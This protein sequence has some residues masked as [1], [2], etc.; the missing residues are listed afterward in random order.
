MADKLTVEAWSLRKIAMD[1]ADERIPDLIAN[2]GDA[3]GRGID[4]RITSSG[5]PLSLEGMTAFLAWRHDNGNQDMTRFDVVDAPGG[6]VRVKYPPAMMH[7]G[8]VIARVAVYVDTDTPITGSR[9]FRIL[10]EESPII[11]GEA[12][13]D[14]SF[15]LFKQAVAE[16][17]EF[18]ATAIAQEEARKK[19]EAERVLAEQ[20]RKNA[21]QTRINTD[22]ARIAAEAARATAETGRVQAEKNRVLAESG[23]DQ[24]FTRAETSVAQAVG[25]ANDAAS[26]ANSAAAAAAAVLD[27]APTGLKNANIIVI[28]DSFVMGNGASHGWAY[29]LK[30]ALP[31][32]AKVTAYGG[33]G[34]GFTKGASSNNTGGVQGKNFGQML[35]YAYQTQK[36]EA[37][38]VTHVIVQGSG[39]DAGKTSQVINSIKSFASSARAK[40]P[41]AEICAVPLQY[42]MNGSARLSTDYINEYVA[43]IRGGAQAGMAV[44]HDAFVWMMTD[45][46][47]TSTDNMHPNEA[48]YMKAGYSCASWLAGG[49]GGAVEYVNKHTMGPSVSSNS[50]Y[51]YIKDGVAY[52]GGNVKLSKQASNSDVLLTLPRAMWPSFTHYNLCII[53]GSSAVAVGRLYINASGTVCLRTPI[54]GYPAGKSDVDICDMSWPI[55]IA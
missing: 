5:Q 12:M 8:N 10:V 44:P 29:Y 7:A 15:S 52:L 55:G 11:E 54:G 43:Y 37:A 26:S 36:A 41:N 31:S 38:K 48:G 49:T 51:T 28:G 33:G 18:R 32:S 13:A 23:R 24:A 35:D 47:V 9:D 21:E 27:G 17:G 4:L 14:E 22:R 25:R 45:S 20:N 40:F 34:A 2:A 46:D 3:N 50:V 30:Q 1:N 39:N 42:K 19:A 53:S 16:V 6:H